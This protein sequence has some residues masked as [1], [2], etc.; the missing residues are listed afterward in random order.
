MDEDSESRTINAVDSGLLELKTAVQNLNTQIESIQGRVKEYGAAHL[1]TRAYHL[2]LPS[3]RR[4]EKA[5]C[6]LKQGRKEIALGHLRARKQLEDTLVKRSKA[7]ENLESTL[8]T[9]EHA[10]G[11]VE[12]IPSH[13][14]P[15]NTQLLNPAHRS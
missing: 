15:H 9:V 4:T 12:V 11:D 7:L 10:A 6:A 14:A 8:W 5:S 1:V 13:L 2:P 3:C